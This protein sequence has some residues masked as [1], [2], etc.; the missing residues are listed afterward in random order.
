[1]QFVAV[2]MQYNTPTSVCLGGYKFNNEGKRSS[3]EK[4]LHRFNIV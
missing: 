2:G 1:V 4:K 3:N